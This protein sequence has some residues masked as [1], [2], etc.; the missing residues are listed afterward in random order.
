MNL[1]AICFA[2]HISL[3]VVKIL[4]PFCAIGCSLMQFQLLLFSF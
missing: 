2:V 4:F 3:E 1:G